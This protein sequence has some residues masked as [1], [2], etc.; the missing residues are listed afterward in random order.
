[1]KH[2]QYSKHAVYTA[3]GWVEVYDPPAAG[4]PGILD[5]IFYQL[6]RVL[7]LLVILAAIFLWGIK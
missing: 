7:P 6:Y 1:M 5:W 4:H 3:S 2:A